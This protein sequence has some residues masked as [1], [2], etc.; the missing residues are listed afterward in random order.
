[1]PGAGW[2][3]LLLR[4]Y[5]RHADYYCGRESFADRDRYAYGSVDSNVTC[6][7]SIAPVNDHQLPF[8]LTSATGGLQEA[9]NENLTTPQTNTVILDN[10]F[11]QMV[12]GSS[13]AAAVI[14][15]AQGSPNLGLVDVTQVP[16]VWYRWNGSQYV[17]VGP[18]TNGGSTLV[19]DLFSNGPSNAWQD[20]YAFVATDPTSLQPQAAVTAANAHNGTAILQPASGRAPFVNTGNVRVQDNRADVPATARGA[21]EFGAACDLRSVY[22]TLSS[23]ST[24]CHH[25][26]RLQRRCSAPADIGRTLVAVGTVAGTPTAF[27]TCYCVDYR[28]Q[29]RGYDYGGALYPSDQPSDGSGA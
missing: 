18:P 29:S 9:L 5:S 28:Q 25:H 8:Y 17:A 27:E 20:L 3:K 19:N 1:M 11:Y 24:Y 13:N 4:L 12:G 7:I 26:W 21:T 10:E 14:A 6:A 2:R 16:T 22:G 23:G 15:A